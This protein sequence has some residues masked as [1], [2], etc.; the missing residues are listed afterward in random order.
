[1]DICSIISGGF[2]DGQILCATASMS[3]AWRG[4]QRKFHTFGEI[5]SYSLI[6]W[7]EL[8]LGARDTEG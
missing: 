8:D 3:P 5:I 2:W 7:P 1:M 6:F 4:G